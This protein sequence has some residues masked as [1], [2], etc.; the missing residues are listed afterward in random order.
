MAASALGVGI[1]GSVDADE[2]SF[3]ELSAAAGASETAFTASSICGMEAIKRSASRT[4]YHL[5]IAVGLA[6][7]SPFAILPIYCSKG[8]LTLAH[9]SHS[10]WYAPL[11]PPFASFKTAVLGHMCG[12]ILTFLAPPYHFP[13]RFPQPD[14]L[15]HLSK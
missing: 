3:D 14:H 1:A 15:P 4:M 11:A 5:S 7:P 8:Q 13:E 6:S 2:E 12:N 9:W 10:A